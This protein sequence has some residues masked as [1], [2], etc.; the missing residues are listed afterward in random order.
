MN[1]VDILVAIVALVGLFIGWRMGLVGAI[2]NTI[3]LVVGVFLATHFSDDIAEWFTEKVTND[4]MATVLGY[5][6]IIAGVYVGSLVARNV[7]KKLLSL[8]FLGWVDTI[9]A[10]VVGLLF[11]LAMSGALILGLARFSTDVPSGGGIGIVEVTG[12]R[13]KL[14]DSLVES[15][16]VSLFIDV[17]KALPWSS[18]GFVPGDFKS[19]LGTVETRIR[20]ERAVQKTS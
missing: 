18:M 1:W 16:M 13:G 17:T 12:F 8:V 4:T 11:G 10:V 3:G 15:Q 20:S 19:A 6:V 5:A 2:F 9:G 7:V 14:Q